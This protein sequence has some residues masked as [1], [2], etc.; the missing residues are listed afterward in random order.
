MDPKV[1]VDD[2]FDELDELIAELSEEP[3]TR[4]A[5]ADAEELFRVLR[6]LREHRKSQHLKQSEV[7]KRMGTTQSAVSKIEGGAN[8]PQIN[9][10]MRYA[11]AINARV[12]LLA[13][14]ETLAAADTSAWIKSAAKQP[15]RSARVR[16]M[17]T[18]ITRRYL[19]PVRAVA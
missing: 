15:V 16:P 7:A 2:G 17:T 11:R 6:L 5:L 12:C 10:L 14:L 8:D 3:A 13:R 19:E 4:D 18:P 1:S 9:T